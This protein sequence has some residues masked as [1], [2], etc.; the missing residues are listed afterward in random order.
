MKET[1]KK[2]DGHIGIIEKQKYSTK[3]KWYVLA[4]RIF[5]RIGG[6]RGREKYEK[7]EQGKEKEE[8]KRN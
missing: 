7:K 5:Q 2:C 4:H 8:K 3:S 6:V 1:L